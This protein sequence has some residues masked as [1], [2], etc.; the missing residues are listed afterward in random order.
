MMAS[1][2]LARR[3][4]RSG[5][6]PPPRKVKVKIIIVYLVTDISLHRGEVI[7]Q[8]DAEVHAML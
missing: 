3:S 7:S 4:R 8:A 2:N 1:I 6:E 5:V